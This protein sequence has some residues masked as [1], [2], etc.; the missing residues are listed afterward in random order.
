[1]NILDEANNLTSGDRQASYGDPHEH[2]SRVA[3]AWNLILDAEVVTPRKACL[4][5]VM[6][7]VL[8]DAHKPK[9]DNLTDIAGYAR[10]IE[11]I[12]NSSQQKK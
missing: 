8:R 12:E 1:M 9:R 6:L 11:M 3:D 4:M 10:V 7:K 5:M 2:W